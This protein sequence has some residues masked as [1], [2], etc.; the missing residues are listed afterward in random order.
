MGRHATYA[1]VFGTHAIRKSGIDFNQKPLPSTDD[2]MTLLKFA[3]A[4]W[5]ERCNQLCDADK[6]DAA[7]GVINTGSPNRKAHG[8][9][10]RRRTRP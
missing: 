10:E 8:L 7:C 5:A 2:A 1:D 6:F 9:S 3:A 4:E